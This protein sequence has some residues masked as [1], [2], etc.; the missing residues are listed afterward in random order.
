M[1]GQKMSG[2]TQAAVATALQRGYFQKALWNESGS[3]LERMFADASRNVEAQEAEPEEPVIDLGDHWSCL[4]GPTRRRVKEDGPTFAAYNLARAPHLSVPREQEKDEGKAGAVEV[5]K[6]KA[7]SVLTSVLPSAEMAPP[8]TKAVVAGE[9]EDV[10][11]PALPLSVDGSTAFS[12]ASRKAINFPRASPQQ[13]IATE[14]ETEALA[15]VAASSPSE[16]EVAV[17]EAPESLVSVSDETT[18]GTMRLTLVEMEEQWQQRQE[19]QW[20]EQQQEADSERAREEAAAAHWR[21]RAHLA[22]QRAAAE[23]LARGQSIRSTAR[24]SLCQR[25]DEDAE[26]D[27][28]R[29][30]LVQLTRL[31]LSPQPRLLSQ[32]AFSHR[33][34]P[35]QSAAVAKMKKMLEAHRQTRG[36]VEDLFLFEEGGA[37]GGEDRQEDGGGGCTEQHVRRVAL[38]YE[39]TSNFPAPALSRLQQQHQQQQQHQSPAAATGAAAVPPTFIASP[40]AQPHPS[41]ST[42]RHLR[43]RTLSLDTGPDSRAHLHPSPP[44]PAHVQPLDRSRAPITLRK[45]FGPAAK[46]KRTFTRYPVHTAGQEFDDLL[47]DSQAST[48]MSLC[49]RHGKIISLVDVELSSVTAT[50]C[51]APDGGHMVTLRSAQAGQQDGYLGTIQAQ[52]WND[53]QRRVRQARL[54][55]SPGEVDKDGDGDNERERA[56]LA[57]SWD[58][59]RLILHEGPSEGAAETLDLSPV[60]TTFL[61]SPA[62]SPTR[63]AP[64]ATATPKAHQ[65]M[66]SPPIPSLASSATLRLLLIESRAPLQVYFKVKLQPHCAAV[67]VAETL[68]AAL[69]LPY[70][71]RYQAVFLHCL[72]L[73]ADPSPQAS[74]QMLAAARRE[75]EGARE[76]RERQRERQ[77]DQVLRQEQHSLLAIPGPLRPVEEPPRRLC[78]YGVPEHGSGEEILSFLQALVEIGVTDILDE[79]FTYEQIQAVVSKL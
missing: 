74:L 24:G 2:K 6:T 73:L 3:R 43:M 70:L 13:I 14:S 39:F 7:P 48:L 52:H 11:A 18:Y 20:Q 41:L 36:E 44:S 53:I 59:R 75:K 51:V 32:H 66:P 47:F 23:R 57:Q 26:D 22:E 56:S 8:Q 40:P 38:A 50:P 49:T 60:V 4:V 61:T 62:R 65:P 5:R 30:R 54:H 19:Q 27:S 31:G 16:D 9:K 63:P 17:T 33:L 55:A 37:E 79:P 68:Q 10:L 72:D 1:S 12:P 28:P 42:G 78:V 29:H 46:S 58:Q 69:A 64:P 76:Q 77:R 15:S 25:H 34:N 21:A 45:A 67:D 71:S 35:T